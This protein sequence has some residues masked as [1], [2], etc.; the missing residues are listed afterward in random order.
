M[1]D[2][3]ASFS[4]SIP[5]YYDS[6]MGPAQF[7]I[8]AADLV[9]R[10]PQRPAGG[11]L[12]IAC[13][14]GIVTRRLRE[15]LDRSVPLVA[16]DLSTAMLGHARS[17]LKSVAGIEWRE[18]DAAKLPFADASFG[19]V[20][21]AF[22]IMFVPDKKAAFSEARRVLREGGSFVFNVWD[23]LAANPQG[24]AAAEVF[25]ALYPGDAEMKFSGPYGFNDRAALRAFLAGARF[26]EL[27]ME[28]ARLEVSC[29]SAREFASGQIKGTPRGLLLEKRGAAV[30]EV[31]DKVA[32]ALARRGGAAPFRIHGQALVVE[33]LAV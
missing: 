14:T 30:E 15:R 12:E 10:V 6:I 16:S 28:P 4:G 1:V 18:A 23:G 21:C 7:D 25:E 27:R 20:V 5:E 22:G 3:A 31:I 9:R 19:A 17:K 24:Q 2:V 32:A 26:R 33:A 13:G 8:F 11:A 29:P